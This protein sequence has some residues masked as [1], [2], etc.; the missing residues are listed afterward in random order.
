M[1]VMPLPVS[2]APNGKALF[3]SKCSQCHD[4]SELKEVLKMKPKD[5]G[6]WK[7]TVTAMRQAG[8]KVTDAEEAAIVKYL[9]ST[10]GK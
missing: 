1:A 5:S 8:M 2:G 9:V 3:E 4:L 10:A 6:R 7:K